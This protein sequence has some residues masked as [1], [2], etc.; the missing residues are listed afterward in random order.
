LRDLWVNPAREIDGIE[1]LTPDDPR[2]FAGITAFRFTRHPDQHVMIQR[3]LDEHGVFTVAREGSACGTCIRV[4][5]GFT[6]S[7]QDM[8]RLVQALR[9]LA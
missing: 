9:A 6:T 1:I 7:A 5:P 3:L 4:T 8:E 2:L